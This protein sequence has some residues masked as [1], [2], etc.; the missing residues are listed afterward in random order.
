MEIRSPE[1]LSNREIIEGREFRLASQAWPTTVFV[2]LFNGAKYL[3]GIIHQLLMQS[4][5]AFPIIWVDN[6]SSDDTWT[7]IRSMPEA[8]L[9]RSKLIRN[10]VNLGGMGS[11][12]LNLKEVQTDWVTSWHQD[13]VYLKNHMGVM[14]EQCSKADRDVLVVFSDMGTID[15]SDTKIFTAIRQS[16]IANLSSKPG[17]FR[18]NLVQQSVSYPSASFRISGLSRLK[19][20]WHSTSFPDTEI[21]LLQSGLG[22]FLF[23]PKQTMLYRVNPQSASRG[24]QSEERVLGP[25]ASLCRVFASESFLKLCLEIEHKRR[26]RFARDV[27]RGIETRIGSSPL[28][29]MVKL[30]ASETMGQAWEYQE[31]VSREKIKEVYAAAG[32]ASVNE[33][34]TELG[35]FYQANSSAPI[36]D[37]QL[38]SMSESSKREMKALLS[39]ASPLSNAPASRGEKLL[40][41][42]IARILPL[43]IRRLAIRGILRIY[44]LLKPKSQWNLF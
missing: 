7:R 13:D 44:R 32:S 43:K 31:P 2:G 29:E 40:L 19:I 37:S 14:L 15:F 27:L 20:P 39:Q 16:W 35:V 22:R 34:L 5:R 38:D 12:M 1:F 25:F 6:C 8:L 10:P 26:S 33:L 24:L 42:V 11:F 9:N 18:S 21:T 3:E 17:S 41:N 28:S 36:V 4:C 23:V 30:I